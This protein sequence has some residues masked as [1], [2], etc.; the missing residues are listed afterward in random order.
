MSTILP[1]QSFVPTLTDES[2]Y[3][4]FEEVVVS[5]VLVVEY[6]GIES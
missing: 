1:L 3:Y 6:S 2:C 4:F 5:V